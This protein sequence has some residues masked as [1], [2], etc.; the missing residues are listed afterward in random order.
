MHRT[1]RIML[2]IVTT[3]CFCSPIG[4]AM[5]A[6]SWLEWRGDGQGR[7]DAKDLPVRWGEGENIVWKTTVPG[8]GWSTP[9]VGGGRVWVTTA[10]DRRSSAAE[11]A[12]RRKQSTN[13]QPL[14]ISD[15]VSLRAVCLDLKTGKVLRDVE[16]LSEKSPQYIHRENSYATPTPILDKN[17]LYCHYGPSGIGCLDTETGDVLWT[18][19]TLR[20][21]HENGPGS[22]PILWK[23]RLIIHCDGIDAQYIVA[24]DAATGK[25][26][27]KSDRSG[28]LRPEAQMRKSYATSLIVESN[29]APQ[30][31][32]PAADWIYGYD[33]TTGGELWKL[34]YGELG[35]SNAPRPI[36]GKGMVFA[37]TGYM[38][39]KM[40]ALRLPTQKG[41]APEV[42]WRFSKQVPNVSSPLLVGDAIYFVSD[43]GIATCLDAVSG[44]PH[45]T[46]R[47]G[48]NFWASPIF[49]DGRIYFFDREG[50]TTVVEPG[51]QFRKLAVN[52]LDGTHMASGAAIDGALLLRTEKAV[53]RIGAA[54]D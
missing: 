33:P 41:A 54:R 46:A 49:A 37:C 29:G 34:P 51:T 31:V 7:S 50:R 10:V 48:K 23:D 53:Y 12:R 16:V 9:V 28:K 3:V 11:A 52:Q 15:F 43:R 24:L 27:W 14:I 35:F 44:E 30:V 6:D 40:L 36:A 5:A 4:S 25:E 21:K 45:W 20:V 19:R 42:V 18:N 1:A 47:I 8:L 38:K 26:I 13:S 17:R 2:T 32:S 22:S 39:S